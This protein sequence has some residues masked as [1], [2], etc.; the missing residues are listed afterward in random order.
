MMLQIPLRFAFSLVA[1][2]ASLTACSA[3]SKAPSDHSIT[4][5]AAELQSL[6]LAASADTPVACHFPDLG[7]Q[8]SHY[9]IEVQASSFDNM[10][11]Y[12]ESRRL[13]YDAGIASVKSDSTHANTL[14][15]IVNTRQPDGQPIQQDTY[16]GLP[17]ATLWLPQGLQSIN[18]ISVTPVEPVQRVFVIGD[19][20]VCDQ[21][22]Q[23]DKPATDRFSGWGQVLPA[24]FND[25]VSIVNYA[26]SGEGTEAFNTFDGELLV[27]IAEQLT[28]NDVVLI[29]L[30]H[31]DKTTPQDVY[32]QRLTDLI[33][34]IRSRD[35][36][37]VLI[38]PMLR[39]HGIPLAKQHQWPQL[40]IPAALQGI[41]TREN[42]PYIDL[43]SLS[44]QWAQPLGQT[45]AQTFFVTNDR[46]HTNEAG[47]RVFAGLVIDAIKQQDLSL[48]QALR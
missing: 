2:A 10:A 27:P 3:G 31:N 16:A 14:R 12:A 47:A 19:S 24:Y 33:H 36:Q 37:P 43:L 25:T 40:D 6:C 4:Y 11:L 48:A 23:W 13:M 34:F 9:A 29:Q 38:S 35:A 15:F 18:S 8:T 32:T 21:N 1:L 7:A 20:T 22:P 26:D 45:T 17:G 44:N 30:G 42:V 5:N 41:A 28:P 46:T 39:N